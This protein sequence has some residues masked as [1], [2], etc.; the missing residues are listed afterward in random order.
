MTRCERGQPSLLISTC[1]LEDSVGVPECKFVM[2]YNDCNP[3]KL[4]IQGAG[5]TQV[6][7]VPSTTF[8][9]IM[10]YAQGCDLS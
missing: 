8:P 4:R 9:I 7:G 2:R 1:T 3:T 6:K 5:I 10:P